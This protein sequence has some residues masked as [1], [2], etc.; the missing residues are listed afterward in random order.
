MRTS[1][2]WQALEALGGTAPQHEWVQALGDRWAIA[3]ALLRPTGDI[4]EELICP[5]SSENGCFRQIVKLPGGGLRAECGDLPERCENLPLKHDEIRIL[6]LDTAKLAR[7]IVLAFDLQGAA[8]SP[9]RGPVHRLGRYEIRAGV[10]FLVFLGHPEQG[11]PMTFSEL[12]AV[13]ATPGP[14]ALLVPYRSAVGHELAVQL[15]AAD[16]R[17]FQLDDVV[18]WDAKRAL[19]PRYDPREL[20]KT[21]IATLPGTSA[22]DLLAPALTLPAG[23]LWSSV[24]IDFENAEQLRLRGPG[25]QRAI[26]PAELGMA[27]VRNGK[28]REPWKWLMRFALH[29]GRM[30]TGDSSAQK[31]KQF[32]SERLSAFTG[33]AEDPIE[34]DYGNYIAKFT[35]RGDSLMQGRAD[36]RRRNFADDD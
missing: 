31:R 14:K 4:A 35:L 36:Q 23:T 33:I 28:V 6:A 11:Q 32:V 17:I 27:S 1:P 30:P 18:I 3:G 25:V 24:S 26:S 22:E 19:G 15:E 2:L 16:V 20:F 13:T 21:I 7:A 12:S 8:T 9:I 29:G 5:K 10:G 34:V